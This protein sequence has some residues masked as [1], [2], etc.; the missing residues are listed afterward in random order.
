MFELKSK[1]FFAENIFKPEI[2][3][4]KYEAPETA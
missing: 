4:T 3:V 1:K 2:S